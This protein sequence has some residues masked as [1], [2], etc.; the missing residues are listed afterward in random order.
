MS[1]DQCF[2]YRDLLGDIVAAQ[3]E[4]SDGNSVSNADLKIIEILLRRRLANLLA[5]F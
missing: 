5:E 2:R 1:N 3:V 4:S